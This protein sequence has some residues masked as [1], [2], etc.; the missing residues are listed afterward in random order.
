MDILLLC[1]K[2]WTTNLKDNSSHKLNSV[3]KW[4]LVQLYPWGYVNIDIYVL[5]LST[6]N[7]LSGA[8]RHLLFSGQRNHVWD[9][10]SLYG[11]CSK[12]SNTKK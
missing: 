2:T 10:L 4:L 8:L 11:K 6:L 7:A 12:I 1:F 5:E 3:H 9:N